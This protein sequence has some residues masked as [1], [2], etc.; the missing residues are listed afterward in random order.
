MNVPPLYTKF[1]FCFFACLL[2]FS[3]TKA[4]EK[5]DST[6]KSILDDS[7]KMKYNA[8]SVVLQTDQDVYYN[9]TSFSNPYTSLTGIQSYQSLFENNRYAQDLGNYLTPRGLVIPFAPTTI[10][11]RYGFSGYDAFAITPDSIS[12]FD[13]RSPYTQLDYTQG[14]KGQQR[15]YVTH[16]RNITSRWN[17]TAMVRR[18]ASK[19]LLGRRSKTDRQAENWGFN[20]STRYY[21]KDARYQLLGT[22]SSMSHVHYD[23]GGILP[24]SNDLTNDDLYNY[25]LQMVRLYEAVSRD[26]RV[27]ARIYQQASLRKDSLIQVFNQLDFTSRYNTYEDYADSTTFPG[28]GDSSMAYMKSEMYQGELKLGVKGSSQRF[29]YALY[30]KGRYYNYKTPKAAFFNQEGLNN[31]VGAELNVKLVQSL[32]AGVKT[33]QA[34][35][36]SEFFTEARLMHK[37]FDVRYQQLQY[38]PTFQEQQLY[39][40]QFSWLNTFNAIRLGQLS[41]LLRFKYRA[42]SVSPSV[43]WMQY[44]NY[45]Y[46][47]EQARPV[48]YNSNIQLMTSTL[49]VAMNKRLWIVQNAIQ[50]NNSSNE[51]VIRVPAWVNQTRL[52]IQGNLFKKATFMQFGVDVFFRSEWLGNSYSPIAQTYYLGQAN[53]PFNQL[54]AYV[55]ADVF[56][57][58]QVKTARFFLKMAYVNQGMGS[59]GY[60][61]TPYYSGMSRVFEFGV[62]WQFF[63]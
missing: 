31:I 24:D 17:V 63:D 13:T 11:A 59:N 33:E 14:G 43:H 10:G 48:Q 62:N 29:F 16:S 22:V 32:Y 56:L 39:T 60:M 47:T 6:F 57:N 23:Q 53:S 3:S 54:N 26:K 18:M 28:S 15:M 45:V 41:A 27:Y 49:N 21:S 36:T 37:W 40:N 44:D 8:T 38:T 42:L 9:R 12:Y 4:Q 34:P 7:T 30:Y 55:L 50:F 61:I 20:L 2:L 46:F 25:E 5:K 51:G 1:S 58:M 35:Q 52:L 19:K